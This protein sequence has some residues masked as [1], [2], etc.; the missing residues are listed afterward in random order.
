MQAKMAKTT[1]IQDPAAKTIPITSECWKRPKLRS[2]VGGCWI[3][4]DLLAPL[5]GRK[6][7]C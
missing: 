2:G 7:T 3:C 6:K 5:W 4:I 1:R